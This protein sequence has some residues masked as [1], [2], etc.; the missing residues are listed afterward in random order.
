M[1]KLAQAKLKQTD[2]AEI[3]QGEH[4]IHS[5]AHCPKHPYKLVITLQVLV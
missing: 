4:Q 1:T 3:A 5:K 2:Y